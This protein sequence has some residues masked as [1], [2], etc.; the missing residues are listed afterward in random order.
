M[1]TNIA[2]LFQYFGIMNY[3][4]VPWSTPIGSKGQG[5]YIVA[6]TN[7]I[8]STCKFLAEFDELVIQKWIDKLP[9]FTVDGRRATVETVKARLGQFWLPDECILYIGK[10]PF[11]DNGDGL[12]N[13]VKEYY[14]TEIG[15]RKEHSGGQWI[16]ALSNLDSTFVFYFEDDNPE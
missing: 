3:D 15:E 4:V 5:V 10:A 2:N 13:R 6:L 16:K 11:R 1:P 12:A 7:D 14:D 8:T 9:T